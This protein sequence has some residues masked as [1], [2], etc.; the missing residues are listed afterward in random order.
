VAENKIP[1]RN[2]ILLG[3]SHSGKTQT[4]EA[5]LSQ[6]GAVSKAGSIDEGT[7]ASDYNDDEKERK[8][9]INLSLLHL[10]KNGES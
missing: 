7:T 4:S 9:S 5:L 1:I 10:V 2:I 6:A 8:I 3:H